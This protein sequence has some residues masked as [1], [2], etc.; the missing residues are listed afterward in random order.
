MA[1][2]LDIDDFLTNVVSDACSLLQLTEPNSSVFVTSDPRVLICA[3]LAYT[4]V[5]NY[6][7]RNIM[8]GTQYEEYFDEDTIINLRCYPVTQINTVK[9][10][11]NRYSDVLTD[12]DESTTL[13]DSTDYRLV[14]NKRLQIYNLDTI[15]ETL[16]EFT[17]QLNAINVY[18][19]YEGGWYSSEEEPLIHNALVTQTVA[20][21]NRI[22][23]LGLT[24][25]EG[26]G[27][28]VRGG[29]VLMNLNL[30]DAGELLDVV[31]MSVS[32]FVYYG[33]AE[34]V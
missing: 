31:K 34:P 25:I 16:Y 12:P 5:T 24:Q 7:N 32:P 9:I 4:Q 17:G 22:P 6:L 18:V 26:G 3:R 23:A 30:V 28:D 1:V 8:H 20:N 13:S 19:E 10:I 33:S 14:R 27:S 15:A 29:R 2:Q 11:D 21:Y